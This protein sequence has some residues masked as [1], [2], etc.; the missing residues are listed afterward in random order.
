[1]KITSITTMVLITL[2]FFAGCKKDQ[3]IDPNEATVTKLQG[4]WAA[5]S[6]VE[7]VYEK[8]SNKLVSE[9]TTNYKTNQREIEYKGNEAVYYYNGTPEDTYTYAIIGTEIRLRYGNDGIYY[10][11]KFYSDIQN[12][13][14]EENFYVSNK[15]EMR[16]TTETIYNKK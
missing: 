10:Q 7:K 14:T 11:L 4:K 9:K 5:T 13:H 15:V 2:F 3:V 6:Q 12:S 8:V 1:M 16:R